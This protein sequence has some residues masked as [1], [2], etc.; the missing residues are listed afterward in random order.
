MGEMPYAQK[1]L[2]KNKDGRDHSGELS[3]DGRI[4]KRILEKLV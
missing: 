3:A 2:V 4:L 1:L